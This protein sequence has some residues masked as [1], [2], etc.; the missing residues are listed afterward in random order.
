MRVF[1]YLLLLFSATFLPCTT[2]PPN[3]PEQLPKPRVIVI[4]DR[5]P[6]AFPYQKDLTLMK[7]IGA[8]GGYT[9]FAKRPIF[10]IRS[11]QPK[12]VDLIKDKDIPLEAWDIVIVEIGGHTRF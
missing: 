3:Q 8:A 5:G 9:E 10:L 11:G 6:Q 7:A 12:K 1:F 4:A 2:G